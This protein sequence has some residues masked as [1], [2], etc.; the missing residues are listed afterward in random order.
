LKL[1]RLREGFEWA[2]TGQA[3]LQEALAHTL[4]AGRLVESTQG[5]Q[6]TPRA[7]FSL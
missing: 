3:R 6:F 4:L 1:A 5:F 2:T 7:F